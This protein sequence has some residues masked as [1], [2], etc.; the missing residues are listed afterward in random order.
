MNDEKK[1]KKCNLKCNTC[2]NYNKSTDF[3][4]EKEIE[5][6]SRQVNTDFSQCESYL[7]SDK[8]VMF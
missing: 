8:L 3:C 6:C 4:A 1:S 7:I 5:N 2:Q